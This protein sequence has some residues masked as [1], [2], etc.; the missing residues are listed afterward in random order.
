[1]PSEKRGNDDA[2]SQG[3]TQFAD[4]LG[5]E[6]VDNGTR[7]GKRG[8]EAAAVFAQSAAGIGR[9]KAARAAV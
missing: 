1:M 8:G 4:G 9:R 7:I 5:F 6:V 3:N 2:G